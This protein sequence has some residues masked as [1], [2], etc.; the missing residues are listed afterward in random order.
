MLRTRLAL[1]VLASISHTGAVP[2]TSRDNDGLIGT[3]ESIL[4]LKRKLT[5]GDDGNFKVVS[6]SDMHFGERWGG[7]RQKAPSEIR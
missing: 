2:L 7:S 6:F 1:A 3:A 5:F 4:G